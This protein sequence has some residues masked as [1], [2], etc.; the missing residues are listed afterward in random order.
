M[1]NDVSLWHL[2]GIIR[3]MQNLGLNIDSFKVKK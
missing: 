1:G 3:E 2:E